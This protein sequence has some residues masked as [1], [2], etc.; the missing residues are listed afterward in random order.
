MNEK[1]MRIIVLAQL[2]LAITVFTIATIQFYILR[3]ILYW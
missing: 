1:L 2:I 3:Q